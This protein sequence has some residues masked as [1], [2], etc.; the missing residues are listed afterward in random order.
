MNLPQIK[1]SL[2][3]YI[4]GLDRALE[5]H[6]H[7]CPGMYNGVKMAMGA[8][9]ILGL[10][11]FPDRDLVVITETDRCITDALMII[12]GC[13]FGRKT[14]KFRD[15]GKFA[16]TFALID[17]KK[18]V[19]ISQNDGMVKRAM[20]PIEEAGID[21]HDHHKSAFAFLE[22]PFY[23]HFSVTKNEIS[24]SDDDLPGKLKTKVICSRCHETVLDNRHL[25]EEN[26]PICRDCKV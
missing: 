13:R 9:Q 10:K 6:G 21:Y 24:F 26:L 16:A 20:K 5:F 3:D 7:I 8:M 25:V 17:G 12:T 22:I 11:E 19:R 18:G 2:E 1:I 14:M 15:V 23:E 4:A